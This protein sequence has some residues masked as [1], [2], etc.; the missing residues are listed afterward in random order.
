MV[1]LD[2][3]RGAISCCS[4]GARWPQG[5]ARGTGTGDRRRR[6]RRSGRRS[7]VLAPEGDLWPQTAPGM[8]WAPDR[9]A[10]AGAGCGR[11]FPPVRSRALA[12][13]SS[14]H[15]DG[16]HETSCLSPTLLDWACKELKKIYICVISSAKGLNLL[17]FHPLHSLGITQHTV[18]DNICA[19]PCVCV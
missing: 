7:P 1:C 18:K 8:P 4:R 2:R 11:S 13:G 9:A 14:R 16:D 5:L 17:V 3:D 10:K 19:E 15:R 6:G 12:C